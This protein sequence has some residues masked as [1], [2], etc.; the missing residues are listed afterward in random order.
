MR[1]VRGEP[2]SSTLDLGADSKV[3]RR[4]MTTSAPPGLRVAELAAAVGVGPDTVRYYERTGLLAPAPRT[5]GG[6]R[7]FPPSAVDRLRFIQG[8][9]RLGLRLRDIG[10][11]LSIRDTGECPCEPAETLLR[12]RISELDAELTRLSALR[13]D[14]V[15]MVDTL[16][17]SPC[18]DPLPGSWCPPERR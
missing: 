5:P 6:Y 13:T 1:G 15:R 8:C 9:Q 2:G 3:Y 11:L 10:E 18:L 17:E 16:P 4:S 7:Q 12:R 14:L